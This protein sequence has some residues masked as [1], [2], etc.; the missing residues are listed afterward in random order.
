MGR[1][2]HPVRRL[3]RRPQ[4]LDEQPQRRRLAPARARSRGRASSALDPQTGVPLKWN[5]GRNPRGEAAYEIYETDAGVWIVSDTDWIGDRRYQRPRIAFFP[6]DEGYNTASKSTGALP[7]NVYVGVAQLEQRRALPRQRRRRRDRGDRR[8]PGLGRRHQRHPSTFHNTGSTA[9]TPSALTAASL[10]NVPASTP[11]R[12][13]DPG[14]QRRDRPHRDA[15]VV[16]GPGGHAVRRCGSTSP[17]GSSSRGQASTSLI[18][19]VAKLTNYDLDADAGGNNRGTMKSFDITSDGTV[20]IDFTHVD[21]DNPVVNAIEI[22]THGPIP[23]ATAANVVNFDGTTVTRRASPATADFDWTNVRGAV[24]IGRTLFYGQTDNFLYR[25]SF[26]G[27]TFGP[28]TQVNP[29]I[30]PLWNTVLTGSGPAT[31]T[32]TGVLPTWYGQLST[33]T[34]M[35][36]ANGRIYY[37][38]TGQNTLYWRWFSPDSGIVGGV[39]NTVTGRQHHLEHHQGDVPRRRHALR[40]QHDQRTTCSRSRSSTAHPAARR[41]WPTPRSTGAARRCSSRRCC[42]TSHPSAAFTWDCTGISCNFNGTGSMDTDGTIQS[43]EWTFGDGDEAGSP[44]PQ[45]DY[46]ATGTYDVTLT[47]TD[48]GGLTSSVTHQVS[49]VKPNVP[50]TAGVH[51]DCEFLDCDFDATTSTDS[52]GTIDELRVGLR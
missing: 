5:P 50:P 43:Y 21:A 31:Q 52:D 15:L 9:A 23:N 35:F 33:V 44:S 37:T 49:V 29:Y 6:Y 18:D 28:A 20:N 14:A 32:Y 13:L 27:V 22:V 24:M 47:V 38:K 48:D 17:T 30:D 2:D 1:R 36:Y 16:P 46:L 4:P 42:P 40:G 25:R 45:K 8:R 51:H 11:T 12:R 26:D 41:A 10:V 7:G 3:R 34:G 39:E 19:G